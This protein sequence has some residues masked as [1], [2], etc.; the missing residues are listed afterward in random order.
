MATLEDIPEERMEEGG[1][2][3]EWSLKSLFGHMAFWDD[4]ALQNIDLALAGRPERHDD[5]QAMNEA[6]HAARLGRS[7]PEER[8]AMHQAHA[9]L[10]E[11]LEG[12]AG[13]EAT[14]IDEAIKGSSYEHY[15]EHTVDVRE[16]RTRAGVQDD[17]LR[18][19]F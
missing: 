16:W 11:R 13:L 9:A 6:D 18:P 1:V 12:V 4:Q 15:A 17:Q 19:A 3:G 8:T 5:W 7:L 14:A 2:V 10:I